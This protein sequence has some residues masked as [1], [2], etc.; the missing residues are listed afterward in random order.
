MGGCLAADGCFGCADCVGA[1]ADLHPV[2][3]DGNGQLVG[4]VAT[5]QIGIPVNLG[6]HIGQL[7]TRCLYADVIDA[8]HSGTFMSRTRHFARDTITA[9]QI[10]IIAWG[11]NNE[12][13]IPASITVRASVEYPI[14]VF[15]RLLFN[16]GSANAVVAAG[17][18][19]F[20][21][22]VSVNIPNGAQFFIRAQLVAPSGCPCTSGFNGGGNDVGAGEAFQNT[23][24]DLTLSGTVVDGGFGGDC[25]YPMAIIGPTT[26]PSVAI[27]G[28]SRQAGVGEASSDTPTDDCGEIAKAFGLKYAYINFGLVGDFASIFATGPT[29]KRASFYKYVDLVVSNF[30]VNDLIGGQT[31]AGLMADLTTISNTIRPA[32]KFYQCTIPPVTTGAWTNPTGSD[33][34]LATW[35]AI[36]QTINTWI[37]SGTA[38]G[39]F[40]GLYEVARAVEIAVDSG[41]WQAPN[42]TNDGLHE[43]T[44]GNSLIQL[45]DGLFVTRALRAR[46]KPF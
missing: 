40:D 39:I 7:A 11:N 18:T 14:G 8:T 28:D 29:T 17:A 44:L 26:H 41:K 25:W 6:Q 43:T 34:T 27:L 5:Q 1:W 35:N 42:V 16:G 23:A 24:S 22:V 3:D 46:L 19:Q 32:N 36:R 12:A 45:V 13:S 15:T 21:D 20:T 30:G 4:H 9:L 2:R 33:Q 37:R 38:T 10:A 31:A